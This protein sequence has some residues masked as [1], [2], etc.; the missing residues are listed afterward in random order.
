M[1]NLAI[2]IHKNHW[3][4]IS[5]FTFHQEVKD[6][7]IRETDFLWSST[8]GGE[9]DLLSLISA[10]LVC[11]LGC[12]KAS[13]AQIKWSE[14]GEIYKLSQLSLD[15][16]YYEGKTKFKREHRTS[17]FL[18]GSQEA[19]KSPIQSNNKRRA[20]HTGKSTTLFRSTRDVRSP[21]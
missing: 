14:A 18:S 10:H 1:S 11:R 8:Y 15:W 17:S 5:V 9:S 3:K 7:L 19:R 2:S 12:L 4:P 21:T 20:E 13:S 6:S 16:F